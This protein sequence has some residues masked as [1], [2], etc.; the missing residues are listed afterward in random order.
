MV[1]RSHGSSTAFLFLACPPMGPTAGG[2]AQLRMSDADYDA[3]MNVDHL[4]LGVSDLQAGAREL[5]ERTGV[6]AVPGGRHA[7]TGTHNALLGLG[8]RSYLELIALDPEQPRPSG[9]APFG[10]DALDGPRLAGWA[11]RCD[12]D[13]IDARAERARARGYDPGQVVAMSRQRPD[14][15]RLAW[16]LTR[17]P[18][19]P[20]GLL[21]PFLIDWGDTEHPS[22]S[23][24]SGLTLVELRGEH[25]DPG[26]V[27]PTLAAL[28]VEL[29]VDPGPEP[30]LVARLATP[31]G[32]L[33]LR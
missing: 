10:L 1:V 25:P 32:E 5:A 7:G 14:G 29:P 16:R 18:P 12:D 22:R 30:A 17:E 6:A 31:R 33:V 2:P 24:P 23:S 26:S 8:G 20:A 15:V 11:V 9:P 13:D 28:G 21:V 27:L 19:R 3:A 4:V